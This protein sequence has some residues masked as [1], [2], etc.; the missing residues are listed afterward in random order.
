MTDPDSLRR[1][2]GP[3]P[4]QWPAPHRAEALHASADATL[5]AAMAVPTDEAA[6]QRAVLTRLAAPK[7]QAF[8]SLPSPRL[9]TAAYAALFLIFVAF[10]YAAAGA[11]MIGLT[12]TLVPRQ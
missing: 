12:S 2:F 6:L 3:E 7:P 4:Q 8:A 11:P 1:R 9:L 10:G 5:R